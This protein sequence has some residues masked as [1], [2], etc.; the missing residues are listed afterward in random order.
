VGD[1]S[2]FRPIYQENREKA[3]APCLQIKNRLPSKTLGFLIRTASRG[4]GT[5]AIRVMDLAG[6]VDY[7]VPL[8]NGRDELVR[9]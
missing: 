5:P 2:P 3:A 9:Y 6:G 1:L 8:P 4:R 7:C